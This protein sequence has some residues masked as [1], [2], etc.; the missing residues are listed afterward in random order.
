MA[1][2]L[3][4]KITSSEASS[5][6][7]TVVGRVDSE[8]SAEF[9]RLVKPLAE[10]RAFKLLIDMAGCHYISSA[11][12]SAF[13]DLRKGIQKRQGVVS[14]C[15]LQP[16]IKKVFEIVKALPLECVFSNPAQ[17][18][19]YLDRMMSEELKKNPPKK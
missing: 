1:K 5:A 3:E 13:F 14:F 2:S 10:K 19:A 12:V 15:S 8:T 4:I 17:A 18:D 7:L 6:I 11:G 9:I 16:Q